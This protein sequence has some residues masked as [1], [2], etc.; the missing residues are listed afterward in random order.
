WL[1]YKLAGVGFYSTRLL[2]GLA[3]VATCAAVYLF[4]RREVSP[5]TAFAAT[6]LLGTGYFMLTNNRAGFVESTQLAFAMIAILA[7]IRS[8]EAP[9]WGIASALALIASLLSKPSALP[10]GAVI[11]A[12]YGALLIERGLTS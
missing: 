4:V 6:L 7:A 11:V 1:V 12:I 3:G 10:V 2:S 8:R 9:V 5:R